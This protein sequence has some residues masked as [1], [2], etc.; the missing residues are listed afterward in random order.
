[1]DARSVQD[2]IFLCLMQM[3]SDSDNSEP[4]VK[5]YWG[6]R[7]KEGTEEGCNLGK[8][9]LTIGFMCLLDLF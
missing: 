3:L 4:S 8:W 7:Q 6:E 5:N 2:F 9:L 1:M